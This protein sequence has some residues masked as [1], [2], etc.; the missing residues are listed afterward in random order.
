MKRLIILLIVF[1]SLH[2]VYGVKHEQTISYTVQTDSL[3]LS[4]YILSVNLHSELDSSKVLLN[5]ILEFSVN[6]PVTDST[7]YLISGTALDSTILNNS[8]KSVFPLK[9]TN[10]VRM[11]IFHLVKGWLSGAIPQ[12]GLVLRRERKTDSGFTIIGNPKL[13]LTYTDR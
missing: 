13:T 6:A 1:L 8:Y 3:G 4:S 12:E 11:N 10:L 5:A 9:G 2:N 7:V